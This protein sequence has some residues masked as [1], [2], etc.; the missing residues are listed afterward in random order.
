MKNPCRQCIVFAM[1]KNK[2]NERFQDTLEVPNVTSFSEA[3]KCPLLI[4]YLDN[5]NQEMINAVR[6]LYGLEPMI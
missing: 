5:S 3:E 4:H 6:V 2:F 1:C